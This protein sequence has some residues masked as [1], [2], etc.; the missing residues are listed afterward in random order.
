MVLLRIR[1]RPALPTPPTLRFVV[2]RAFHSKN[3]PDYV[4]SQ[5]SPGTPRQDGPLTTA[6]RERSRND[7]RVESAVLTVTLLHERVAFVP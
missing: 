7:V 6:E 3:L 5:D 4:K 2:G 1:C